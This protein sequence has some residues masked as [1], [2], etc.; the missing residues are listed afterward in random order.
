MTT[1][2]QPYLVIALTKDGPEVKYAG[3]SEDEATRLYES[4][5]HAML[6]HREAVGE[7]GSRMLSSVHK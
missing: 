2:Q 5:E 6:Q 7:G 1:H 3:P 4:L